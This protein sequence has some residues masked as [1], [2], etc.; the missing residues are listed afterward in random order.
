MTPGTTA[1]ITSLTVTTGGAGD[2]RH[3]HCAF[4]GGDVTIVEAADEDEE[5]RLICPYARR[6]DGTGWFKIECAK[7]AAFFGNMPKCGIFEGMRKFK[8]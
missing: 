6:F 5:I 7:Q 4:A 8:Q 1:S 2:E 3:V